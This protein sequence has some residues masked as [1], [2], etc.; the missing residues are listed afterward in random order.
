M[1]KIKLNNPIIK[2]YIA[3]FLL[4]SI[5]GFKQ[6]DNYFEINKNLE[7]F[8]AY[9]RQLNFLYHEN[10]PPGELMQVGIKAMSKYLDPYTVFYPESMI[11]ES[12]LQYI[13]GQET[14]PFN[15]LEWNGKYF[16]SDIADDS[17]R[18]KNIIQIGDEI[19]TLN[20][21]PMTSLSN[22]EVQSVISKLNSSNQITL[23]RNGDSLSSSFIKHDLKVKDVIYS[24]ILENEG[25]KVGYLKFRSFTATCGSAVS[26][27]FSEYA[28]SNIQAFVLD[29]RGNPGGLLSEAVKIVN[30]F[31]PQNQLVV[32]MKGKNSKSENTWYTKAPPLDVK[33]QVYILINENSASASEIV[34][35]TLQDYDRAVVIGAPSYG[36]G[37]VQQTR[38]LPYHSKMKVTIAKYYTASGRCVQK[39]HHKAGRKEK[40]NTKEL[41]KTKNG[42]PVPSFNGVIP[43]LKIN[44]ALNEFGE[45]LVNSP[46]FINFIQS[47]SISDFS[48]ENLKEVMFQFYQDN[49]FKFDSPEQKSLDLLMEK[50]NVSPKLKSTLLSYGHSA[51]DIQLEINNNWKS[52]EMALIDGLYKKQFGEREGLQKSLNKD[53]YIQAVWKTIKNNQYNVI[54]NNN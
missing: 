40:Y 32:S 22:N 27:Y 51:H 20:Q 12:M 15:V 43:D 37:L 38:S 47:L 44:N 11:E 2:P 18:L 13:S 33:K 17:L 46:L 16:V 19:I 23:V 21:T 34:S 8:N 50:E 29:L 49:Q 54:L 41:F 1:K 6:S 53:P 31:I 14:L 24:G 5:M 45:Q 7:Q 3:L 10:V 25:K 36:K 39:I 28:D 35:G 42:R 9:Y 26:K 52:I 48:N 4:F 30:L